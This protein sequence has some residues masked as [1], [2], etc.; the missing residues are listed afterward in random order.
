MGAHTVKNN[1]QN[2]LV[3]TIGRVYVAKRSFRSHHFVFTDGERI[4]YDGTSYDRYEGRTVFFFYSLTTEED[5]QWWLAD[6]A[7]PRTQ[8]DLFMSE[9]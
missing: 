4:R 3:F 8:D 9:A 6:S 1:R 7:D 5:K 2:D